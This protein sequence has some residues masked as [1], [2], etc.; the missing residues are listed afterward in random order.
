MRLLIATPLY[1][2][3]PGGPATYAKLLEECLPGQGV[4][5][6]LAKFG[7]VR[8]HPKGM[9]HLIYLWRV[10]CAARRA[11]AVLALDPV[12]VG[13]PA[14]IAAA[15]AGK[16]FAVKVVGD[17]AWEQGRQRFGVKES[18]DEFITRKAYA[19][20]VR[21][22]RGVQSFVASRAR[23]VI[24]PGAYLTRIVR[25]WGVPEAR[26]QVI[27]N[28]VEEET[29]DALPEGVPA[30]PKPLIVS[31]GR[32][33]PWKGFSTLI[34]A[35]ALV[36][37]TQ[38]ASLAIAGDGPEREALEARAKEALGDGYAFAGAVSHAEAFALMRAADAFVLGSTYEGMSHTLVE[39]LL[40]G[41][42][43]IASDIEANRD[44][45]GE[46]G[47]LV[48]PEDPAALAHALSSVFENEE[49]K[50]ELARK[51]RVRGGDFSL[52]RMLSLTAASLKSIT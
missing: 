50:Q 42:P 11:D 44:V 36:R 51:A 7:E 31:I 17:Y 3:D 47:I 12:S 40:S 45:V 5:V 34:D 28:A 18:L 8:A 33:V 6:S 19:L 4:A 1:P 15:L 20:P 39:A 32:L 52:A 27:H 21:L 25:S 26:I 38:S 41:V 23:L 46:A 24:V 30:L 16:P 13:L 49:R 35:V 29:A 10:W 14:C 48:P 9:R 22:M 37:G 2:P 43:V